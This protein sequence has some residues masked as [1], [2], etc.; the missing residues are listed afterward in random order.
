MNST[1]DTQADVWW[2]KKLQG[3]SLACGLALAAVLAFGSPDLGDGSDKPRRPAAAASVATP[4]YPKP[5]P[6]VMY[7]VD[8]EAEKLALESALGDRSLIGGVGVSILVAEDLRGRS[9]YEI[10]A[11]ELDASVQIIDLMDDRAGPTQ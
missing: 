10:L 11:G 3:V 4:K 9:P 7:I 5:G 1:I 6:S 2:H 8:S